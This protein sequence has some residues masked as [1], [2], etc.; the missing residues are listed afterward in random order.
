MNLNPNY[1][2]ID[3]PPE[4]DQRIQIHWITHNS[5]QKMAANCGTNKINKQRLFHFCIKNIFC[6]RNYVIFM[7]FIV[8][9]LNFFT[10]DTDLEKN[11]F[12]S[13]A[14]PKN[15]N[16]NLDCADYLYT[17]FTQSI[18]CMATFYVDFL[19][20]ILSYMRTV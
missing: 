17:Q 18:F 15:P 1:E 13:L 9:Y 16:L 7:I 14:N 11:A 4:V 19:Q 12:L 8:I 6:H 3:L 20:V 2:S 5:L 10:M